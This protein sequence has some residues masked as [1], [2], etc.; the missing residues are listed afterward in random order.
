MKNLKRVLSL[1]LSGIMLVGMMAVG[2]SAANK[3]FTDKDE[4]VHT[5]AVDVMSTLG[6]LKGNDDGSYAPERVVTRGEMA[7]IITVMLNGGKDPTLGSGSSVMFSDIA[8]HW[9]KNYIEYCASM[10]IIAGRGDGTFDPDGPVTGAAAAKMLLVALGYDSDIFGFTG[11]DWEINVNRIANSEAKLYEEIKTIDTSAGLSR[12]NTAQMAYNALEARLMVQGYDKVVSSGEISYNYGLGNQTFLNK[13]F[14]AQ[15]FIGTFEGNNATGG[16]GGA[17]ISKGQIEIYGR[18]DTDDG[19]TTGQTDRSAKFPFGLDIAGI[20]EQ[21]KVIFKDGK[22]G[23]DGRPDKN[24]TIYGVFN[25][26][27]VTVYTMTKGDISDAKNEVRNGK[28]KL[29][30]ELYDVAG[31]STNADMVV[32]NYGGVAVVDANTIGGGTSGCT[33]AQ[34]ATYINTPANGLCVSSNDP[35]KFVTNEDGEIARVYVENWEYTSVLSTTSKKIQLEG[36]GSLDLEKV[37]LIDEVKAGDIVA[38]AAFYA[39]SSTADKYELQ[40]KKAETVQGTVEAIQTELGNTKIKMDGTWYN[41]SADPEHLADYG[42][43]TFAVGDEFELVLDGEKYYAAAKTITAA[44]N[45]AMVLKIGSGINDQVRLLLADG[46]EK[47]VVVNSDSALKVGTAPFASDT[48]YNGNLAGA[49]LVKYELVKNDTEVKMSAV[50]KSTADSG[51]SHTFNKDTK[52]LSVYDD[53]NGDFVKMVATDAKAFIFNG[54]KWKVYDA[55]TIN[56]WTATAAGDAQYVLKSD[57]VAVFALVGTTNPTGAADGSKFGFVTDK[58]V[59]TLNGDK[60]VALSIWDGEDTDTV[61]V[62]GTSATA[63]QGDFVKYPVSSVPVDNGDIKLT[64]D[65]LNWTYGKVKEYDSARNLVVTTDGVYSPSGEL[66]GENTETVYTIN[67]D[68]K[69]IG[70]KV[71]GNKASTNN[72]IATYTKISGSDFNNVYIIS[73]TDG[74]AEVIKAIFV[75]ED[76]KIQAAGAAGTARTVGNLETT[77]K[78]IKIVATPDKTQVVDGEKVT[79]TVKV[80]TP[81]VASVEA[82]NV[83]LTVTGATAENLTDGTPATITNCTIATQVITITNAATATSATLTLECTAVTGN[84]SITAA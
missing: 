52:Q 77:V 60:V 55:N 30:G 64:G 44:S 67:S 11:P 10:D 81:A 80:T 84:V 46:T 27:A 54:T 63:A 79:Y 1:A 32:T 49:V 20:G 7:K 13:Y 9:A 82:G 62:D 35:V 39:T 23:Q 18:L 15:V 25:T 69:I 50:D 33:A 70:V 57:K 3:D 73:E 37:N 31:S 19:T 66:V 47:T 26:G 22:G 68:T 61:Y 58:I 83:T 36:K 78:G 75:D 8:N 2:A 24:D 34:F 56:T 40:V 51:E 48:T 21:Y 59:T 43:V 17:S 74:S 6:V 42:T 41:A 14:D 76:N 4:I 65:S 38:V 28:I 5:E 45:Y 53:T 71:D 29:D 16:R 12:D 72:S